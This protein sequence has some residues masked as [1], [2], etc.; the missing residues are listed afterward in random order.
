MSLIRRPFYIRIGRI[1]VFAE[2]WERFAGEPLI[3]TQK[4]SHGG[5]LTF[6]LWMPG[7]HLIIDIKGEP[8]VVA[9]G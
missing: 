9:G 5:F 6:Q 1:E 3:Q 2:A 4:G 8:E 7:V